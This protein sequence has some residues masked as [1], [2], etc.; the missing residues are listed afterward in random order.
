M[1]KPHK[2]AAARLICSTSLPPS[3]VA[4]I[5]AGIGTERKGFFSK[6]KYVSASA[7][8]LRFTVVGVGGLVEQMTFHVEV[9][10]GNGR[11]QV[12]TAIDTFL[13]TQQKLLVFIPIGPKEMV[14]WG[15]YKAYMR[16]LAEAL[17][18]EDA[19]VSFEIIERVPQAV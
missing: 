1:G 18:R 14:A 16:E 8:R 5:A 17:Q 11:A 6:V 12:R 7:G 4:E 10:E 13:T 9:T 19:S 3:R 15:A 2:F